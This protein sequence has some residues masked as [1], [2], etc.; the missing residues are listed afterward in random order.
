M[1]GHSKWNNIKRKKEKT[2]AAKAS[3]F[4]RIGRELAVAVKE[5]GPDPVSNSKLRDV[6][7]KAKANNVPNDNIDRMLKKAA[8]ETDKEYEE[9]V[10]EG[11]GPNGDAVVVETL[12][13]NRNRTAGNVRHYFDKNGGNLGQNG[14]VM[15]M[16]ERKGIIIM[17]AED[18]DEDTVMMDALDS[19]ADDFNA[20][21]DIF[22][23]TT[24]PNDVINVATALQEK[25]YTFE[26]AEAA[27]I[28]ATTTVLEDEEHLFK[29]NRMLDMMEEDDDIQH[30]WH[31]WAQGE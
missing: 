29:M 4:T 20:D 1:S 10:Y 21:G 22:E 5:G 28:P 12:T 25:G 18:L 26:S 7:A 23:I 27:Y 14:S 11:Y 16:F 24:D 15:F 8:G 9:I 2:D 3:V 19:G 17:N 6:I 30:V 13:D 31:S